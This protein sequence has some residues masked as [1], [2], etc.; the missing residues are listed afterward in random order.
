MSYENPLKHMKTFGIPQGEMMHNGAED[1]FKEIK[2]KNIL[3]V[4]NN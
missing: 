3:N 1:L 2:G 4:G